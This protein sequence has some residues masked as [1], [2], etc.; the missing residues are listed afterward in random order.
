MALLLSLSMAA[1]ML[2]VT[3]LAEP[4]AMPAE[5]EVATSENAAPATPETAAS[6]ATPAPMA[7][8]TLTADSAPMMLMNEPAPRVEET[9]EKGDTI[10]IDGIE[11]EVD[12]VAAADRNGALTLTNGAAA[13][14][15]LVLADGIEYAGGLYDI[16]ALEDDAFKGNN[17]LTSIDMSA[18]NVT[19]IGDDCFN[20]CTMLTTVDLS[21]DKFKTVRKNAFKGC[22]ALTWVD[23]SGETSK[24]MGEACFSGCSSLKEIVFP[25]VSYTNFT[26]K[27][28]FFG[29]T[30]LT[31]LYIPTPNIGGSAGKNPF[32]GCNLKSLI[33]DTLHGEIS[34]G[35]FSSV[36]DGFTLTVTNELYSSDIIDANA[37]G[38][39]K[40]VTLYLPTAEDVEKYT[41]VFADKEN[42]TVKLYGG[43]E[44]A[45]ATVIDPNGVRTPCATLMDAIA[46]VNAAE[47]EGTYTIQTRSTGATP[48]E[49]TGNVAPNKATV[50][51]FA[52][53]SVDLPDT[54]TLQAPLTIENI[55]NINPDEDTLTT[56]VAG[57][58]AFAMI[59]GGSFGFAEIRGSDL[60]FEGTLPGGQFDDGQDS[61]QVQLTGTG[62][63]AAVTFV[64]VGHTDYYYNLPNMTGFAELVLDGAYLEADATDA[65]AN[66]LAGT[67]AVT[68][69][70]GGLT[71]NKSAEIETISGNGELR[72]AEGAALT[73]T[74]SASGSF[75]LPEVTGTE[76]SS[77][78][79]SL[80]AGSKIT[81]TNQAG[82]S[83]T[84]T[85]PVVEDPAV[86]VTGGS[87]SDTG[88]A[89][90]A[91]AF[92]AITADAGD[93]YTLTLQKDAA[94]E[95]PGKDGVRPLTELPAKALVIDGNGHTLTQNVD[96]KDNVVAAGADLTLRNVD[97]DADRMI[98][99]VR[100]D[101]A[102]LTV[103]N[104][105]SGAIAKLDDESK[106]G[107]SIAVYAREDGVN[108]VG[109]ISGSGKNKRGEIR[110]IGFGSQAEPTEACPSVGSSSDGDK[111]GK[112]ILENSW[113]VSGYGSKI[114][115]QASAWGNAVIRTAGGVLIP[116]N[117][118]AASPSSWTVEDGAVA[119]LYVTKASNGFNCLS[120]NAL[121]SAS[122]K[123]QIHIVGDEAPAAGDTLVKVPANKSENATFVIADDSVNTLGGLVL[124]REENGNYVL[125]APAEPVVTVTGGSLN[126]EGYPTLSD[127]FAAITADAG[128]RYALTLLCEQTFDAD[129]TLPDAALTIDGNG[130]TLAMDAGSTLTAQNSLTL[131]NVELA[132]QGATLTYIGS[133]SKKELVFE[134]TVTGTLSYISDTSG[135]R[136]LSIVLEDD[137]FVFETITGTTTNDNL[138]NATTT[139]YL[140]GFGSEEVP[141]DLKDKVVNLSAIE[142]DN[143]WLTASGN[144]SYLGV[145]RAAGANSQ[146]AL[147]LT[148]DTTLAG[149][150]L[151]ENGK[152]EVR[153]PA[154]ATLMV[155]GS[156]SRQY[157]VVLTLTGTA[158]DG[159]LLIKAPEIRKE[160]AF[161]ITGLGET[162]KLCWDSGTRQFTLSCPPVV[163][164]SPD[165]EMYK[166][167]YTKPVLTLTDAQGIAS[168]TVNSQTDTAYTAGDAAY[169][170]DADLLAQGSNTVVVTD[171]TGLSTA[172]AFQY[173]APA[174]YSKVEQALAQVPAD[175][176]GYTAE[177]V[178][179]LQQAVD[180]VEYGYGRTGQA[181]VDAMAQAILDAVAALKP[182]ETGMPDTKP[183]QPQQPADEHPEI[184]D[185]IANGTWGQPKPTPA[186]TAAAGQQAAAAV[187]QT[188][189]AAAPVLW[190][191]LAVLSLGGAGALLVLRRRRDR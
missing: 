160:T 77:E 11:Y 184:A 29:C 16:T 14:G 32:N 118:Q 62:D 70:G 79:L 82:E 43:E 153:M 112:L 135:K 67:K 102:V 61:R 143:C 50:I 124:V 33:V 40:T 166:N 17:A 126:A 106:N 91:D 7:N 188:A 134:D 45:L 97:L 21:G 148:G 162:V 117:Q 73:V 26:N 65:Y 19:S 44:E 111:A 154:D 156:Y 27:N 96:N 141:V 66:Q 42:V 22:T 34:S 47:T 103:E 36:Q 139:L 140:T 130:C 88:Y 113:V 155:T 149:F 94:L 177:S 185:A 9:P 187:P 167:A 76:L 84:I 164:M 20:G 173:D 108:V 169:T 24:S 39:E 3:A 100:A 144:A 190:M 57:E 114:V 56:L 6:T 72:V 170:P 78:V 178:Q 2:P 168:V 172:F 1:G 64:D 51:D 8:N 136:Y 128:D 28:V 74:G 119:D 81:L 80:P 137:S 107:A 54:L 145:V 158:E 48:I 151:K 92:D 157:P 183:N 55:T 52:G 18:S 163:A 68:L 5:T 99:E 89:T 75:T 101:G 138:Q 174:D 181:Q 131:K 41:A 129:T 53:A 98:L 122:G 23:L 15:A 150:G 83:V 127:A 71:V 4:T 93:R 60:T 59:D 12:R 90:L 115:N 38:S 120:I 30:S 191:V 31:E 123:T 87:L 146:G 125:Q 161:A 109:H 171:T 121:G 182:A 176:S 10:T 69:N 132:M 46:A 133:G 180:G 152:F 49:W 13:S 116:A 179:A 189:D 25:Q 186:P 159:H 110:L 85:E 63:G 104:T 175:L 37:F 58:H 35:L 142:L 86:T 147:T 165:A 95:A 105:V